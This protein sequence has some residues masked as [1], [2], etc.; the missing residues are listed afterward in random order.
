MS[1][2]WNTIRITEGQKIELSISLV[3]VRFLNPQNSQE[4]KV[5]KILNLSK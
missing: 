5:S 2:S 4:T 3:E 1:T